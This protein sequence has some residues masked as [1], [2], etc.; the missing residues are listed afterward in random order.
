M[1]KY[2]LI[3]ADDEVGIRKGLVK[4][5]PWEELGY[6][7]AADFMDGEEVIEYLQDNEV[8]VIFTDVQM[9]VVSGLEVARWVQ[10][11][12]RNIKV[13][14]ISGFREFDYIQQAMK[15]GVRD[16]VLKPLNAQEVCEIF[17]KLKILL[18]KE[19]KAK[20]LRWEN[21]LR[22]REDGACCQAIDMEEELVKAIIKGELE[23][24]AVS[25]EK[26]CEKAEQVLVEYFPV[27]VLHM[28]DTL[29]ERLDKL[30]IELSV[31]NEKIKRIHESQSVSVKDTIERVRRILESIATEI[32]NRKKRN[33]SFDKTLEMI[34]YYI[35]NHL[36]ENF[37][38]EQL[39]ELAGLNRSYFSREF[40][41]RTGLNVTEYILQRR[42]GRA[43]ELAKSGEYTTVQIAEIV[44][45]SDVKYFRKIFKNFTGYSVT[46]Y[47]N[48][49]QQ[50]NQE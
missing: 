16:Y 24:L 41:L 50:S 15:Y 19:R 48:L 32:H 49:M 33:D 3:V 18:D 44:G 14:M 5:I 21:V 8:D 30:G 9:C 26:W 34:R 45:Y 1:K 43:I 37:G 23:A 22:W 25:Y 11:Q 28:L 38:V 27:I 40:K 36:G 20:E 4:N 47:R 39:A 35:D 42:V 6:E 31:E 12:Q 7:V 13:V 46:E 29:Y 17:Q 10:E 2:K